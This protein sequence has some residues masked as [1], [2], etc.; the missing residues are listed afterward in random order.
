MPSLFPDRTPSNTPV[1]GEKEVRDWH[2]DEQPK[3]D[4]PVNNHFTLEQANNLQSYINTIAEMFDL[5]HWD[6]FL[7]HAASE[8]DCNASIHAVY[9]RHTAALA[10]NKDWFTYPLEKQRN[11][12][13]HEVLHIVHN[14]QTEVIRTTAQAQAV[15]TTFE[16]E[17]ELM[18]DGLTN[19]IE[20]F[21]PLPS[22]SIFQQVMNDL[23]NQEVPN[24]K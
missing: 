17:T 2:P 18:V 24:G 23:N 16:R 21:F 13:I 20:R 22:A 11:T 9:G 8:D 10:V 15:W 7:A 19:S 3:E 4:G 14:R 5:G 1:D 6:I 12:I